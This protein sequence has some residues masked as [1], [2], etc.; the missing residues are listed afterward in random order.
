MALDRTTLANEFLNTTI[1]SLGSFTF[2]GMPSN[3]PVTSSTVTVPNLNFTAPVD[4]VNVT[5]TAYYTVAAS[6]FD[7]NGSTEYDTS[8][9]VIIIDSGTTLMY[10]PNI[11]AEA[12]AALVPS[13][14]YDVHM[15]LFTVNCTDTFPAFGVTIRGVE[16]TLESEDLVY[17]NALPN[18]CL[19]ALVPGGASPADVYI[20]SVFV[21]MFA[22]SDEH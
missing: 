9:P 11:V 15:Q 6:S 8:A 1:P 21:C 2:G 18:S 4:N 12:Y 7:F 3:V 5:E 22:I 17:P 20:L 14:Q 10:V 19:L 16:F 13:S